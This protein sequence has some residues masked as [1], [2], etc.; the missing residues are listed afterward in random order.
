MV[1][2]LEANGYDVSYISGVDTDRYGPLLKDHQVFMSSGHDEYW[3]ANQRTNVESALNA[4]VDLAFFSGN[5]IFWKV[6]WENSPAGGN[7]AYRTLVS[8]KETHFNARVDPMDPPIST[9]TWRDPRFGAPSDGNQPENALM[10]TIYT[11]DPPDTFAIQVP[12]ADG[13]MRLWRNTS[14]AKQASGQVATLAP[15]T[16]GYEWDEDLDNGFR[17][18][19]NIDLSTT[20]EHVVARLVDPGNATVPGV[21]THHLTMHRAPSGALVFGA[22]TV[23]WSWGLEGA[24]DGSSGPDIRMEQATVNL[25]ADMV[26]QPVTLIGGLVPATASTDKTPPTS[27][28]TSPSPDSSAAA[29]TTVKISGTATDTGG[30]RVAGVEISTNGGATWHPATGRDQWSYSWKTGAAGSFNIQVRATDD[31]VNTE[32]PGPGIT[33]TVK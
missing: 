18:A 25:L 26:V 33:I 9:G 30:G 15:G 19:G 21:A 14:I 23:Q 10:G 6:R 32:K 11:V 20:T 28:I 22:G 4:G 1:E 7:A 29:G 24:P 5:S 17:P 13:K 2:F 16:L 12:A 27:R 8:Y 31:S 3:S